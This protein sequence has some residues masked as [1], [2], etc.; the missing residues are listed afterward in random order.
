MISKEC[1]VKTYSLHREKNFSKIGGHVFAKR[2]F[3]TIIHL[4]KFV[5]KQSKKAATV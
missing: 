3:F 2:K 4:V 5:K 1:V